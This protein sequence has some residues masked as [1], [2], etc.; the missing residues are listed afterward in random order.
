MSLHTDWVAAKKESV[1]LFKEAQKNWLKKQDTK[2]NANK[3]AKARKKAAARSQ[4]QRLQLQPHQMGASLSEQELICHSQQS[5]ADYKILWLV[6]FRN[7]GLPKTASRA[8]LKGA[9]REGFRSDSE[10]Q[11]DYS[12]NLLQSLCQR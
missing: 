11:S 1:K 8:V 10:R 5:L 12:Y 2:I 6:G 3:D 4:Y 9:L 7:T